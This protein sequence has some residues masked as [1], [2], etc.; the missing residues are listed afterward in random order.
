MHRQGKGSHT[1]EGWMNG[2]HQ[3]NN[4]LLVLLVG[5]AEFALTIRPSAERPIPNAIPKGVE[6]DRPCCRQTIL[7]PPSFALTNYLGK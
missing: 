5:T 1:R 2:R 3:Q 7:A 4:I 6:W